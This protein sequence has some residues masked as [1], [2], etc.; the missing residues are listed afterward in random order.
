VT[1]QGYLVLQDYQGEAPWRSAL[2]WLSVTIILLGLYLIVWWP[3]RYLGEGETRVP[4][5]LTHCPHSPRHR[6]HCPRSPRHRSHCPHS[7]LAQ[8]LRALFSLWRVRCVWCRRVREL[9]FLLGSAEHATPMGEGKSADGT[10][11]VP[12]HLMP[13]D[14]KTGLVRTKSANSLTPLERLGRRATSCGVCVCACVVPC[15]DPDDP[16]ERPP[17]ASQVAQWGA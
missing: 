4:P 13:P 5:R 8:A 11:A 10:E 1:W 16:D 6:S 3:T 14:E 17:T 12:P 9:D 15:C 2:Y 7:P